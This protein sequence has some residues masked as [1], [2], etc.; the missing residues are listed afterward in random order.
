MKRRLTLTALASLCALSA[1]LL[2][3][4]SA[5]AAAVHD[6]LTQIA[7]VPAEGPKGEPVPVPGGFHETAGLTVDAGELYVADHANGETRLDRFDASSGA[8][9]SQFP[10]LPL[11]Y[12]DF[13]Q[14]VAVGHA[15]GEA[16]VYD[17]GDEEFKIGAVAVFGAAGTLQ[18]VW[19]GADT[20]SGSFGCLECSGSPGSVAVDNSANP[21]TQGDIYVA[22]QEQGV[23]DIF[24]PLKGGG[25]EY[26]GQLTGPE[27]ETQP[28][29]HFLRPYVAV[30][31][32]NGDVMV[33]D[34]QAIDVFEP[35]ALKK[36]VLV[37]RLTG[38]ATGPFDQ[39]LTEVAVDGGNGDIYVL[40]TGEEGAG[41][42]GIYQF[43]FE[44]R[45][46]GRL[47][48]TPSG[49]FGA[50]NGVAVDPATHDVYV[51]EERIVSS[52]HVGFVDVFGPNLVIPDVV[53]AP[54]SGVTPTT[55]VLNGTVDPDE[56]GE[57]TCRFVWGTSAEFGK[58]APCEPENV[59]NGNSAAPVHAA[60]GELL[61]DTTYYYRLQATNKTS[62]RTNLGEPSQDREFTTSG[63]GIREESVSAVTA[64]S[65]TLD[66]T[67]NAHKTPTSYYFEYGT[68]TSYG[69][70]TPAAPGASIGSAEGNLDV[71][72]HV[73]DL[74]AGTVYHY[75]VVTVSEVNPGEVKTFYGVDQ[76]FATQG[77]G[78]AF[79]LLDGRQWEM[80]SPPDKHG[81]N[82]VPISPEGGMIQAAANG[83]AL[84]FMTDFP[85]EVEPPGSAG[86]LESLARRGP[87]G[88][89]SQAIAAPHEQAAGIALGYGEE[90]RFFSEDLS[91]SVVH[92]LGPFDPAISP[93]ASEQTVF[94]RTDFLNGNVE[95][96][97]SGACFRPLV[98]SKPGYANV[99]PGT[100][101]AKACEEKGNTV[102]G[103]EILGATGDLSHVLVVAERSGQ[104]LTQ[105]GGDLYEWADGKLT[106]VGEA[107]TESGGAATYGEGTTARHAI[108]EDGSRVVFSGESEGHKGLLLRDMIKRETVTL[109]PVQG[110]VGNGEGV[111]Q[112]ASR[113]ASR[114]F[115]TSSAQLTSDS[116][117]KFGNSFEDLA[118]LYECEIVEVGGKLTCKLSDLTPLTGGESADVSEVLG[119]SED[120]SYVYFVASG[121]LAEGAVH[122]GRCR[123]LERQ[124]FSG[125]C[126]LYVRHAGVTKLVA[127]LS[128]ED[129]F[130]FEANWLTSRVSPDGRWLTFMSALNL[131]GSSPRDAVAG[132][133][134]EQV[135]LYDAAGAGHLVCASCSPSGARPVGIDSGS[136]EAGLLVKYPWGSLGGGI[137]QGLAANIP[138]WTPM[139][140]SKLRYQS[141]ALSD[142]GRLFFNS[143]D[144]LVPQDVNGTWDVYEYEPPGVGSCSTSSATFS[145]RSDGCVDLVSSGTSAE[146]SVFMDASADGSDVFFLTEAKLSASDF[147]TALDVY[148]A[149]ECTA[150][151]P[152]FPTAAPLPP[153]CDTGDACKASPTPQPAIFGTPS[154]ATF[155]GAGN[156]VQP[157]PAKA[158]KRKAKGLTR[159]QKLT[160]ALRVCRRKQGKGRTVCERRAKARYRAKGSRKANATKKGR[161]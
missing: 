120:G 34:G 21:L 118:D 110:G 93:E 102:C 141:R 88:W 60:L 65:A 97:C 161:G 10:Q 144:A 15:T 75:R 151:A 149:H 25:E 114:V 94:M 38:T 77:T 121:A 22:A 155:S 43:N 35:T 9:I 36:Y 44:G 85:T 95:E 134:D 37:R 83:D 73:Q 82:V 84:A 12:Y 80:V 68:T 18:H 61:P 54:A 23:V 53:T 142:G 119:A 131:T 147:D 158:V 104:A 91:H 160:R 137:Y 42:R 107:A 159:A 46:L 48:G 87:N 70:D 3:G 126:N 106:S 90:Y 24:K 52:V 132:Q 6:Y 62:G 143:N 115:F 111:F 140:P 81:A 2:P 1:A 64:T 57:A 117:G 14:S 30:S 39:R 152:C 27:P 89:L 148:D 136:A 116:G 96:P 99:P 50:L 16:E 78:A 150:A 17:V 74:Q 58:E 145:E 56:G 128:T 28:E 11:P 4:A 66:A 7:G 67:I 103:P 47:T 86:K 8:F 135:Y 45:Y 98:T 112:I 122:G 59:A 100:S 71:A 138:A 123:E 69:T 127:T 55:T 108:S 29:V 79:A 125:R 32:F 109:D 153:P 92:P 51:G 154:S 130:D 63:A 41:E 133:P 20:P 31:Q 40:G 139:S 19:E 76:T 49:A 146:E 26:L 13:R 156:V 129:R 124:D 113:D 5:Q 105:E 101:L 157:A 33:I 72:R